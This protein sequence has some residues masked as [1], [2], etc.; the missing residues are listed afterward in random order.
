MGDAV[1]LHA[2]KIDADGNQQA[3][4]LLAEDSGDG[5]T[6]ILKSTATLNV[7]DIQIGATEQKDSNSATRRSVKADG[8]AF[9]ASPAHNGAALIGLKNGSTSQAAAGDSAGQAHVI[10]P[11]RPT[12]DID[13]IDTGGVVNTPI[14]GP[15][16]AVPDGFAVF[17]EADINNSTPVQVAA[18]G[19]SGSAGKF[20]ILQPGDFFPVTLAVDSLADIEARSVTGTNEIVRLIV[21]RVS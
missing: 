17:I 10:T 12:W 5:K 1:V 2:Y 6:L 20:R 3:F 9:D 11:N 14:T 8:V 16:V 21:E 13:E 18:P 15:A 19:N 4:P 7:G